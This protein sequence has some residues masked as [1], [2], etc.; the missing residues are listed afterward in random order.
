MQLIEFNSGKKDGEWEVVNDVVMG[1]RS[2]GRFSISP[3]RFAVFSGEVSLENNGGFSL[4]RCRFDP[5][6]IGD[7]QQVSIRLRGDGKR[8]QFRVKSDHEDKHAYIH[9]FPTDGNWETVHLRLADLYPTYKGKKLEMPNFPG[10]M[11]AE[12]GFLIGNGRAESFC[13]KLEE[14]VLK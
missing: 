9:Y 10:K 6:A 5:I 1:G 2:N 13:L 12:V 3:D 11:L 14:V 8:Y 7:Y 4:V